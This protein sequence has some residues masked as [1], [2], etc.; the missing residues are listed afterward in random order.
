MSYPYPRHSPEKSSDILA[1]LSGQ[2]GWLKV[3]V[4]TKRGKLM[5]G[6]CNALDTDAI[7]FE[8]FL[9]D[10]QGT[11]LNQRILIPFDDLKALFIVKHFEGQLSNVANRV[12]DLP[13]FP[14]IAVEFKDGEIIV[15]R[16]MEPQWEKEA[17]ILLRPEDSSS[18][19]ILILVERSAV[20]ALLS[21]EAYRKRQQQ[22]FAAFT[23]KHLKEGQTQEE[24]LGDFYFSRHDYLQ[25]EAHYRNALEQCASNYQLKHK[26]SSTKYNIGVRYIRQRDY[27]NALRYME[28]VLALDPAHMEASEKA[29][30]LR[31]R[32]RV[33]E[34]LE[35]VHSQLSCSMDP[36]QMRRFIDCS[37]IWERQ[38]FILTGPAHA[39][40]TRLA[41]SLGHKVS[42]KGL[43]VQYH[44]MPNLLNEFRNSQK[45]GTDIQ[46]LRTI[47]K[48]DL[49]ILDDW[50]DELFS[51]EERAL[52]R[53]IIIARNQRKATLFIAEI[54]RN[55]WR[56]LFGKHTAS[57]P[58][59]YKILHDA[60]KIHLE[61]TTL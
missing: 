46:M 6:L 15:G 52:F 31:E 34:T 56:H 2:R 48:S 58:V 13:P 38:H 60:H 5:Y 32:L 47:E 11:P 51:E 20:K 49:L 17:H 50:G 44:R 1:N 61:E 25:A 55:D 33:K 12:V 27:V 9:H 7:S 53:E 10:K 26:L 37:W 45:A 39:G 24:C 57:D 43:V 23:Q 14:P 36:V 41:C 8:V 54:S 29:Q 21:L 40:K 28:L 16:P 19:N 3:V 30:K 42:K 22:E 4:Q 35:N 59:L 18:N